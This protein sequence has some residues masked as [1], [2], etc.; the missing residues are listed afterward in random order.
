MKL[1]KITNA[2]LD[3]FISGESV[4]Q[5]V[6]NQ[7]CKQVDYNPSDVFSVKVTSRDKYTFSTACGSRFMRVDVLLVVSE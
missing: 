6:E 4:I 3:K 5:L 2:M 1:K 7:P